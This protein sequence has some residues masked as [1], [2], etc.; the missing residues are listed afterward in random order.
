M[1]GATGPQTGDPFL[2]PM[3]GGP[4]PAIPE[5]V[6]SAPT[7]GPTFPAPPYQGPIPTVPVDA[8][9]QNAAGRAAMILAIVLFG[10]SVLTS[11]LVGVFGTTVVV[12]HTA[13]SA[14]F[15][16]VPNEGALGVQASLGSLFGIAAFVMG[17]RAVV[18]NRGRAFGIV[19]I[20]LSV[21]API[22][23]VIVWAV[24]GTVFGHHVTQ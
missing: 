18:K 16:S 21:T 8:R 23:S 22:V 1:S 12:Y 20:V 13:T 7:S 15:N 3:S 14:G 9:A 11:V 17:L 6:S 4:V 2:P 19:A 10:A 5:P 24:V